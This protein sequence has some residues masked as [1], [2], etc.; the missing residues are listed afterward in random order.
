MACRGCL[1]G[2]NSP[3]Y[4]KAFKPE[5]S[6]GC[7]GGN[8]GCGTPTKAIEGTPRWEWEQIYGKLVTVL[9][10]EADENGHS[11]IRVERTVCD[12]EP[13]RTPRSDCCSFR[14]KVVR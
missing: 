7:C 3:E 6:S 2:E 1:P 14:Y 5:N 9:H 8:T 4:N 12:L 10:T 11:Y 13:S